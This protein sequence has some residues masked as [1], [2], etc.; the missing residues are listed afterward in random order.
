MKVW[1]YFNIG[2]GLHIPFTSASFSPS[3]FDVKHPFSKTEQIKRK[4]ISGKARPDRTMTN[5]FFCETV[6]CSQVFETKNSYEAHCLGN[7]HDAIREKFFMKI[8]SANAMI[9]ADIGDV[10]SLNIIMN[11]ACARYPV[12]DTFTKQGWGLPTRSSFRYSAKQ[13]KVLYELFMQGERNNKKLT[14][15]QVQQEICKKL[16]VDEFVTAKQVKSLYSRWSKLLRQGKLNIFEEEKEDDRNEDEEHHDEINDDTAIEF[17]Q[18]ITDQI[19]HI[20]E[21]EYSVHDYVAVVYLEKWF[22]SQVIT[23]EDTGVKLKSMRCVFDGRNQFKWPERDDI[24][25]YTNDLVLCKLDAPE[26][27]SSR[28]CYT[29][30]N[31]DF[32]KASIALTNYNKKVTGK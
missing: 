11:M 8:S 23:V 4:Q 19:A 16:A 29:L 14:P 12:M 5:L 2:V 24:L 10:S 17:N 30:S 25:F 21:G 20:F 3:G 15:E 9:G 32:K 7:N 26:P 31:I 13:K 27:I 18:F 22:P 6:G 1:R 28:N